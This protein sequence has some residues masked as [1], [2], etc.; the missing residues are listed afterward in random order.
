MHLN[1]EHHSTPLNSVHIILRLSET[2][3]TNRV[4]KD[5]TSAVESVLLEITNVRKNRLNL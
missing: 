3:R 1:G 4:F 5:A 2:L